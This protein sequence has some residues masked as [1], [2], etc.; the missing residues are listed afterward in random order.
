[1]QIALGMFLFLSQAAGVSF[2]PRP[3]SRADF[4]TSNTVKGQMQELANTRLPDGCN[5]RLILRKLGRFARA[6]LPAEC[7]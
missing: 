2:T 5:Q 4:G 1:M 6:D 3:S 7:T